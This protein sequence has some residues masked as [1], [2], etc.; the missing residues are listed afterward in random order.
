MSIPRYEKYKNTEVPWLSEIP[1][2]WQFHQARRLFAQRK[3][4]SLPEDEQ[5]SATQKYGVIPQR[6]FMV[7]EDQKL[8]LALGGLENFKRVQP[9]DFVISLRSFQGGIER[10]KYAGCVSPAYTVLRPQTGLVARFWEYLLKSSSYIAALQTTTDGIREGKNISYAQFG[11]LS[12]PLPPPAEQNTIA[13]FLDRETAKIDALISEQEKLIIL[14]VEKRKATVSYA[15]TK[16]LSPNAPMKDSGVVWLGEV[17]EHWKVGK[18]GFYI[19]VLPGY[20]FS[21]AGFSLDEK[22][23]K[24]LRGINV[25]VGELKWD[26]V[27]YWSRTDADGLDAFELDTG[28]VVIGMDR[29]LISTG[30]RVALVKEQD[31]PCLLLQRVAKIRPGALVEGRFM[32]RLLSSR[33]FEAHFAPE[34]TGVSV[35]HISGEQIANFVISVPPLD[36]QKRICD[37]LDAEFA[38]LDALTRESERAIALFVERRAA[39]ISAAVTGQIDVRNVKSQTILESPGAIAA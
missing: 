9:N 20:A 10:S 22:N 12:V 34:T 11:A 29:P 23:V 21:S 19:S 33:A 30:M 5:L 38:K 26:E 2:H 37:F 24:L 32:M 36:E 7:Q 16:G 15:I 6:L 35:P 3:A 18:A 39:L 14:L 17:P 4:P 13:T 28:D 1:S 25:G 8:V 27:V 31:L